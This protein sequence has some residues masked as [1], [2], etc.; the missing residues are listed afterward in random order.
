MPKLKIECKGLSFRRNSGPALVV[1]VT[2]KKK[3]EKLTFRVLLRGHFQPVCN[4]VVHFNEVICC[5]TEITNVLIV[6]ENRIV[7]SQPKAIAG[8]DTLLKR[9]TI[10][11]NK[12]LKV[13][14]PRRGSSFTIPGPI[15]KCWFFEEMG[16]RGVTGKRLR[17]AR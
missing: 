15:G 2:I 3:I 9:I 13:A 4:A 5:N 11:N 17:R 1:V 10:I 16:K 7:S 8:C 6:F 12:D 14:Y